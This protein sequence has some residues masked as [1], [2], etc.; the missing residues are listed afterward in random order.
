[1][2]IPIGVRLIPDGSPASPTKYSEAGVMASQHSCMPGDLILTGGTGYWT[3][4]ILRSGIPHRQPYGCSWQREPMLLESTN[5]LTCA[6]YAP[7]ENHSTPRR[8]GGGLKRLACHSTIRGGR[9]RRELFVSQTI[10]VWI[11][12]SAPWVSQYPGSPR[13]SLTMKDMN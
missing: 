2:K 11:S 9:R 6:T 10:R 4:T 8:S 1:M 12:R 5:C 13:Q 7:S 3:N